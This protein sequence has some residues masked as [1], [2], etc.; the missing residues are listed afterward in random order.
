MVIESSNISTTFEHLN[1]TLH[2]YSNPL[3]GLQTNANSINNW[4]KL[5]TRELEPLKIKQILVC[6]IEWI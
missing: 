2:D 5:Y 1:K 4:H 6:G 3:K